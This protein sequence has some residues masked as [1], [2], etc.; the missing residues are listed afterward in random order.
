MIFENQFPQWKKTAKIV[1]YEQF[2]VNLTI[3][4]IKENEYPPT[5]YVA[6]GVIHIDK[7]ADKNEGY[8]GG[9]LAHE[10]NHM[11]HDPINFW[12]YVSGINEIKKR[13]DTKD[14]TENWL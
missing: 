11:V 9:I 7:P 2:F 12:N 10:S 13:L 5:P 3:R 1:D 8:Y 4:R 14:N 6:N